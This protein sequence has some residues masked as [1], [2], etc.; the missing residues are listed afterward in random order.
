MAF[1]PYDD[2]TVIPNAPIELAIRIRSD[3]DDEELIYEFVDPEPGSGNIDEVEGRASI[4]I[5]TFAVPLEP[6]DYRI[7]AIHVTDPSIGVEATPI[8]G[9]EYPSFTVS[10][11]APCTWIGEIT[12]IIYRFPPVPF[13]DIATLQEMVLEITLGESATFSMDPDGSWLQSAIGLSLLA[14]SDLDLSGEPKFVEALAHKVYYGPVYFHRGSEPYM[15][16][17]LAGA[18]RSAGVSAAEVT[19]KFIWDVVTRI[20]VGTKGEAYVV[21]SG[22]R[23]IAHPD[24]SLVL[25]QTDMSHL[26][27][28][29]AAREG[30]PRGGD[31]Q[32]QEAVDLQGR[33]IL[34]AYAPVERLGWFVFVELPLAE[35]DAPLHGAIRRTLLILLAALGLA[36]IAGMVLAQRMVIPIQALR[37][38]AARIGSGDLGQ[39]ISIKTGDELEALADQF[40][41]MAGQ[42]QESY[43]G[44]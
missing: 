3:D 43:A 37:A 28:V 31:K 32:V 21:S 17:A 39:R 34:T 24:I 19:L 26:A 9:L 40:N 10:A 44:L 7:M 38:G 29:K 2:D 5:R 11:D 27:Q 30:P 14:D 1:L 23:L 20:K 15:T 18:S 13:T 33:R 25:R 35:A 6:G 8:S 22:G 41:D 36:S 12:S 4:T 16:L 42:L